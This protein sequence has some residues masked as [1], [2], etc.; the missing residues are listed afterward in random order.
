MLPEPHTIQET[1][2]R[3]RLNT[4]T[5]SNSYCTY[6]ARQGRRESKGQ[7]A[8]RLLCHQTNSSCQDS[9]L[10]E[11]VFI[12]GS[13]RQSPHPFGAARSQ[14]ALSAMIAPLGHRLRCT[15]PREDDGS[16]DAEV[17]SVGG[18]GGGGGREGRGVDSR[19]I[20]GKRLSFGNERQWKCSDCFL[21]A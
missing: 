17:R 6:K 11:W 7:L 20:G 18:G 2:N 5:F 9:W 1:K 16:T 10:H 8:S 13:F 21:W 4:L 12:Q 15:A 19:F 14:V 3:H